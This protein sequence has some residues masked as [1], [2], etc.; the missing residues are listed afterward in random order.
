MVRA[1]E[2]EPL[3]ET[4]DAITDDVVWDTA[5]P[6]PWPHIIASALLGLL[7]LGW[8][9]ALGAT[10]FA[11]SPSRLLPPLTLAAWI[12]LAS[13]PLALIAILYLLLLRTGR[14]EARAY[15]RASA[16]L[17]VDTAALADTLNLLNQRIGEARGALGQQAAELAELGSA[18]GDRIG[19]AAGDLRE[20]AS[21][22]G[23][24]VSSLNSA[25]AVARGDLDVLLNELPNAENVARTVGERLRESG[26]E[27]D[28]RARALAE[29]LSR[30][31]THAKAANES[32]GGAAARL[33]SQL[34][35]IEASAAAADKRIEDAAGSMGRAIDGALGAAAESLEDSRQVI[36]AQSGA[37]SALVEQ[38]RATVDAASEQAARALA[39]RLD[40]L[41]ARVQDIGTGLKGQE[42]SAGAMLGQL[43]QAISAAEARFAELGDRGTEHTAELATHI[44]T[45][46]SHAEAVGRALGGSSQTAEVLLHRVGQLRQQAEASSATISD[47]IPAALAR[48][49]LHAEQSLQAIATAGTRTESLGEAAAAVTERL[50]EAESLLERQHAALGEIG[51]Q[52]DGRLASL[53]DQT[54]ILEELLAKA[55]AEVRSLSEGASVQLVEALNQVRDTATQAADHARDAFT[56]AIPRV[57]QRMSESAARAMSVALADVGKQEIAAIG[58]TSEQAIQAAQ[59][60]AERLTRQL[61]TIAET[62]TAIEARIEANR[63]DTETHDDQ[64]FARTA[65]LLIEAL[66][67]TAIDIAKVFANEVTDEEW[68][69]Y[70]RGDRGIFTRRAVRLLDR[71]D[72]QIVVQRYNE[73]GEFRDQVN[74]YI[75]DFEALLRR[76]MATRD[77]TPI[78]TTMLSSDTGKLYVALAQAIER[79]RR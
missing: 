59:L 29:L 7:A 44:G 62:S 16:R 58:A 32:T 37:L 50:A 25:T 12:G 55:D 78:A 1:A 31:D 71:A 15:S 34:D 57:A 41:L 33:A 79:L 69:A 53:T 67:S 49:R 48:I 3:H 56:A 5:P 75:H 14:A 11:A 10:L 66:N 40:A 76:V 52:T 70:L 73:D 20:Q 36:A 24:T 2:E 77:G 60:A 39:A 61:V 6:R 38:N 19:R 21:A 4:A 17:R 27:A 43:D 28:A 26:A 74:R 72:A 64:S 68:K 47:T 42:Q 45:L 18:A 54:R 22:V 63:T 23:A 65:G 51:G 9:L 8:V 30:L 46:S 35:R 13:G